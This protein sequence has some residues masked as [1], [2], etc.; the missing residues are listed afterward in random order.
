MVT[1]NDVLIAISNSGETA[2]LINML[3]LVKRLDIPLICL[4]GATNSSLAKAATI[5]LDVSVPEEACPLGLA[6]TSSTTA[7]LVM[8]DALAIAL[9][10]ARQF[11][12]EDFDY[13]LWLRRKSDCSILEKG[14]S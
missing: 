9:M 6:P 4:S 5:Y 3:P 7:A 2:E 14:E 11:Q 8:G 1:Q 12:H 13:W 10:E